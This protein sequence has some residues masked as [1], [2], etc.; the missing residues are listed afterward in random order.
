MQ[1]L[2]SLQEED[3]SGYPRTL[4]LSPLGLVDSS[5]KSQ[6]QSQFKKKTILKSEVTKNNDTNMKIGQ[7]V[8]SQDHPTIPSTLSRTLMIKIVEVSLIKYQN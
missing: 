5:P 6:L 7:M 2:A 1:V 3:G 4:T 8:R